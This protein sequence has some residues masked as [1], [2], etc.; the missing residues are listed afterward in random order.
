MKGLSRNGGAL[1][2]GAA[3]A[4]CLFVGIAKESWGEL[5]RPE[6][7]RLQRQAPEEMKIAVL[8]VNEA[9][10]G[11]SPR[12]RDRVGRAFDVDVEAKVLRVNRTSV[13][14]HDGEVIHIIYRLHRRERAVPGPGEPQPPERGHEY[15]AWLA[16]VEGE[17]RA[18]QPAAGVYTFERI[19]R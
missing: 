11:E 16:K 13:R 4:T 1:M 2:L 6:Y 10:V 5:P 9:P 12:E 15:P 17:R 3:T 7:R 19:D 8:R 18:F 14:V